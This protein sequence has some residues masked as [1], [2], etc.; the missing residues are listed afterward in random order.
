LPAPACVEYDTSDA[1]PSKRLETDDAD[2]ADA[3]DE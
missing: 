1:Q 2:D 3:D